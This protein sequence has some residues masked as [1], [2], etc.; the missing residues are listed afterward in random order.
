MISVRSDHPDVVRVKENP[1]N[2]P[3]MEL[4]DEGNITLVGL[5]EGP[6]TITV[7]AMESKEGMGMMDSANLGQSVSMTFNV[8]V[9]APTTSS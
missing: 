3:A 4:A 2:K 7:T 9:R 6:A 1:E 8:T 5:K